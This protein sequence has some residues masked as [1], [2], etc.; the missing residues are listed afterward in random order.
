MT[1]AVSG[2][3][4][5][6]YYDWEGRPI[7]IEEW[8]ALFHAKRDLGS[9][10]VGRFM[11]STMW[12]GI[13]QSDGQGAPLIFESTVVDPDGVDVVQLGYASRHAALAGHDQLVA[14]YRQREGPR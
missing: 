2:F 7:G 9:D 10:V 12:L 6:L 11:I 8:D 13:D 4:G 14:E 1:D 3:E 5:S